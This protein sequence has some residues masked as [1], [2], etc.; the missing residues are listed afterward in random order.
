MSDF[1]VIGTGMAGF[2]AAH[3]LREAGAPVRL[4]DRNRS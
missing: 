4:F 3:K 2:C 1:C